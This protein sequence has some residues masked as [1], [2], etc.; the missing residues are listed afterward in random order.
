ML[1]FDRVHLS[2][3]AA[4]V[5]L[6]ASIDCGGPSGDC[7]RYSDCASGLTCAAGKCVA[8]PP[9]PPSDGGSTEDDGNV[10][11]TSELT[12]AGSLGA[13]SSTDDGGDDAP[14]E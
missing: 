9:P 4:V 5:L 13:Q 11:G 12:D 7:L 14:A 1:T 8:P 3:V 6:A 2:L 10:D